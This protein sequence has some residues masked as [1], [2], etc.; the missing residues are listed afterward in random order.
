MKK[1]LMMIAALMAV[2][3]VAHAQ[4]TW[5]YD[6]RR[7]YALKSFATDVDMDE[8]EIGVEVLRGKEDEET[9]R[10]RRREILALRK[11]LP[12]ILLEMKKCDAW[13]QCLAD[14]DRGKVKHC[15]ANDKRWR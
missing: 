13:Y 3:S 2:S 5:E 11:A 15:Y 4:G 7:G 10:I 9:V 1:I 6:C 12:K 8:A 14:R